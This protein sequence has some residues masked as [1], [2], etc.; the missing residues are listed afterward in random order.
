MITV[1]LITSIIGLSIIIFCMYKYTQDLQEMLEGEM[2][3]NIRLLEKL[4]E[5]EKD[6][7]TKN[8]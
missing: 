7:T 1:F 3:K 2:E 8:D 6:D 4:I 5:G